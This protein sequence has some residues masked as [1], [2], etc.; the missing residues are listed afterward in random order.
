VFSSESL[1][2]H[3]D[4][5]MSLILLELLKSY[6]HVRNALFFSFG[7]SAKANQ[8]RAV[9]LESVDVVLQDLRGDCVCFSQNCNDWN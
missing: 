6:H 5:V 3:Q 8:S 7:I 1:S 9:F 4:L 2:G